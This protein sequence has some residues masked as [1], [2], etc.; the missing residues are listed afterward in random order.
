MQNSSL[1]KRSTPWGAIFSFLAAI[2]YGVSPID[3]LPD[4][5]PIIGLADDAVAVPLLIVYGIVL[6]NRGRK[7]GSAPKQVIET[8]PVEPHI[9]GS[10]EE[11]A[12]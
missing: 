11:A 9:P 8:Q 6:Y 7:P 2:F 12:F 3:L 1:A 4:L 10:Y 5:I